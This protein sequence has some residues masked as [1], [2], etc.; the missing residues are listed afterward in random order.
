MLDQIRNSPKG[1]M[2]IPNDP[3]LTGL[4]DWPVDNNR[5]PLSNVDR[6]ILELF[7]E[8]IEYSETVYED[9]PDRDAD[10]LYKYE[11]TFFTFWE[12]TYA[13]DNKTRLFAR[14]LEEVKV[15]ELLAEK[16]AELKG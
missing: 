8:L 12:S 6:S 13:S 11:K 4:D 7:L 5:L 1:F 16:I 2:E 15:K 9:E 10:N 3:A 14:C